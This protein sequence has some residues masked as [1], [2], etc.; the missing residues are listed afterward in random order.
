MSLSLRDN[1]FRAQRLNAAQDY[2]PSW[3][4]PSLNE[5]VSRRLKALIEHLRGRDRP[6]PT[7]KIPV[8]LAPP[9]YGKTHL[10]GRLAHQLNQQA[11]FVFVPQLEDIRKPLEH[12]RW[13]TVESLFRVVKDEPTPLER[14]LARISRP[15]FLASFDKLPPSWKARHAAVHARLATS[16]DAVLEIVRGVR[17]LAPF[18]EL[19]DSAVPRFPELRSDV[20]R[21]LMLGWSPE[22]HTVRR[23]LRGESLAEAD[24]A[25]VQLP[26]ESPDAGQVIRAVAALMRF[27]TPVVVCCDQLESVLRDLE[28][29]PMCLS[30]ALTGLL[31]EV[32]N[33]LI[34]LSCLEDKWLD[35]RDRVHASFLH[36]VETFKLDHPNEEQGIDMVRR[37]LKDWPGARPERG[38]TWPIREQAIRELLVK[39]QPHARALLETCAQAMDRWLEENADRWIERLLDDEPPADLAAWFVQQWERELHAIRSDPRRQPE[40]SDASRIVRSLEEAFRLLHEA[41]WEIGGVRLRHLSTERLKWTRNKQSA[42]Q[43]IVLLTVESCDAQATVLVAYSKIANG[44]E[45]RSFFSKLLKRAEEGV[46]GMLLV[47][48][49]E[50]I[51]IGASYRQKFEDAQTAGRLRRFSL[52]EHPED[53]AALEGFLSLL[54]RARAGELEL[55]RQTLGEKDLWDL[56]IKTGVMANLSLFSAALCWPSDARVSEAASMPLRAA[57]EQVSR[58]L[59]ARGGDVAVGLLQPATPVGGVAGM[60]A[61][62]SATLDTTIPRIDATPL[63]HRLVEVLRRLNLSVVEEGVQVGPAFARLKV[64]PIGRTSAQRVRQKTED[65]KIH[66]HLSRSP[67]V[68]SEA[69]SIYVDIPLPDRQVVFLGPLLEQPEGAAE[70]EPQVPIGVDLARQVHWLNLADPGDCHLLVAGANG[71]GKSE[72]L[73]VILASLARRLTPFQVQFALIAPERASF[74]FSGESPYFRHP[75]AHTVREAVSLLQDCFNEAERR[76]KL[77]KARQLRQ[78]AQLPNGE[79]LPRVV[80]MVDELAELMADRQA[81]RVME[82]SVKRLGAKARAVGVHLILATQR[83]EASVVTAP[84]RS[85]LSGR[86]TFAVASEAD[87]MWFLGCPDAAYLL[88]RGDLLWKRGGR[89]MRL[90]A[91]LV[92]HDELESILRVV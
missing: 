58:G 46:R 79:G 67:L 25:R 66:L 44:H 60:G 86:I 54:D 41:A 85:N 65:L 14:L 21:A 13:H 62:P 81:R 71:S 5:P 32:P 50:R 9:G 10:F 30:C 7:L 82:T 24:L 1:P 34:V 63:L 84:L 77:L 12:I 75:V 42:E 43:N 47:S 16:D 53:V 83:P 31:Q 72:F 69:G 57:A 15:S 23:W 91:P 18:R 33:Q 38:D 52:S 6:D 27:Q 22:R 3:D 56:T 78:V 45:F 37:R 17:Q 36:R 19:A 61:T 76:T 48:P 29:G 26:A 89:L 51:P 70:G 68:S 40:E 87:S 73:K 64:R 88:G 11:L 2:I 35:M 92:S 59:D 8:L 74:S 4:V 39:H 20:V 90:Q 49:G 28:V 80:V 55:A